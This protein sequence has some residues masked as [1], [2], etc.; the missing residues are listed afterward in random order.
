MKR[1]FSFIC[2]CLLL[3]TCTL[4]GF[5]DETIESQPNTI[6]SEPNLNEN[7]GPN[8]N[9]ILW[10][11]AQH[12][13][14]DDT[15][16]PTPS[17]RVNT[18]NGSM[19]VL[20]TTQP[21]NA[22]IFALHDFAQE[23][24]EGYMP[25][26][27][28]T[29]YRID[30]RFDNNAWFSEGA[31]IDDALADVLCYEM[32]SDTPVT[33][34]TQFCLFDLSQYHPEDY[35]SNSLAAIVEQNDA[36]YF[37]D[38]TKHTLEVRVKITWCLL[39]DAIEFPYSRPTLYYVPQV[40][41]PLPTPVIDHATISTNTSTLSFRLAGDS[42]IKL[43]MQDEQAFELHFKY[44][45]NDVS[46]DTIALPVN[47]DT[48]YT[49]QLN[50]TDLNLE[51][52]AQLQVAYYNPNTNE[53]SPWNTVNLTMQEEE[54]ASVIVQPNHPE[55]SF[56][57]RSECVICHHCKTPLNICIYMLALSTAGV[58]GS[59]IC[60]LLICIHKHKEKQTCL[61]KNSKTRK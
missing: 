34:S 41:T 29:S 7:T 36:G 51:T 46:Y 26:S 40:D 39:G 25:T 44:T 32:D 10:M 48:Y 8:A 3:C 58:I 14:I 11:I 60:I 19:Q 18:S 9:D 24:G 20:C 42:T 45:I 1:I 52:V 30:W 61:S 5:A 59:I 27:W 6:P 57:T 15:T 23:Y 38:F 33:Q 54:N 53:M 56:E 50:V 47:M 2:A 16:I 28:Q 17:I 22:T 49:H 31:G 13:P 12:I 35:T 37:I 55:Q 43:L 21:D 4:T